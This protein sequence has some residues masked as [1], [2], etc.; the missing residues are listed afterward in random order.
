[1]SISNKNLRELQILKTK[2][3]EDIERA[4][5]LIENIIAGC[6]GEQWAIESLAEIFE[7]CKNKGSSVGNSCILEDLQCDLFRWTYNH[8]DSFLQ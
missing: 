8:D 3:R 1:M 7:L 2:R 6:D 4:E 5:L